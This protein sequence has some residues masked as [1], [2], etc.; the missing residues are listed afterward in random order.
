MTTSELLTGI[1]SNLDTI[2]YLVTMVVIGYWTFHRYKKNRDDE[3]S[4][5][6]SFLIQQYCLGVGRTLI[7]VQ[8]MYKNIGK[9]VT[10]SNV[11]NPNNL[12]T[13]L[14]I[15]KGDLLPNGRVNSN[16]LVPLCAPMQSLDEM[17]YIGLPEDNIFFEPNTTTK[18]HTLFV[19]NWQ[20]PLLINVVLQDNKG[21]YY[22]A[23]QVIPFGDMDGGKL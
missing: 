1:S 9:T 17:K 14:Q 2:T 16:S 15:P 18:F 3:P 4:I 19:S 5:E 21:Y 8:T 10:E 13:V 11:E 6:I 7:S 12:M 23:E 20:G 22:L